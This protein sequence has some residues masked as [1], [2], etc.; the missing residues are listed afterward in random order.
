MRSAS[1]FCSF[2]WVCCDRKI[3]NFPTLSCPL[4]FSLVSDWGECSGS[5][6]EDRALLGIKWICTDS[7][8]GGRYGDVSCWKLRH[9]RSIAAASGWQLERRLFLSADEMIGDKSPGKTAGT[10]FFNYCSEPIEEIKSVA[11]VFKNIRPFDSSDN[12]VMQ[13]SR[14]IYAGF[15]RHDQLISQSTI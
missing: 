13:G 11:I 14:S 5:V 10:G 7:E 4:R 6:P 9:N 15:S 3:D 8:K 12:D 2:P 1:H